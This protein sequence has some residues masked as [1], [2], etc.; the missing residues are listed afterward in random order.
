[1]L[2]AVYVVPSALCLM[3][4]Y[5]YMPETRG[6]ESHEI[7]NDMRKKSFG[8]SHGELSV[9]NQISVAVVDSTNKL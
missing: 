6:K 1:M 2:L 7:V 5:L 4:I 9:Q 8:S 3:Y